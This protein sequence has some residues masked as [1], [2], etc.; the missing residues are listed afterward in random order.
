MLVKY[1]GV[2]RDIDYFYG[3]EKSDAFYEFLSREKER[4]TKALDAI[5]ASDKADKS[6]IDG[7]E[8]ILEQIER[9]IK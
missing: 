1:D 2:K 7:L 5:R 6:R 9:N 8:K 3:C 4:V